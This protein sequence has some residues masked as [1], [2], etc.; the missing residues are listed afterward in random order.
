LTHDNG[1][2]PLHK[3]SATWCSGLDGWPRCVLPEGG[4]PGCF[5]YDN[6]TRYM[7]YDRLYEVTALPG[8]HRE[9]ARKNETRSG[10]RKEALKQ[11]VPMWVL[12]RNHQ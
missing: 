11:R 9:G 2:S 6:L 7:K 10:Q 5:I 4:A 3:A 12:R 8:V 1:T